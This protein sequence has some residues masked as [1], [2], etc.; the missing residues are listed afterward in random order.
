MIRSKEIGSN[1]LWIR[2][3]ETQHGTMKRIDRIVKPSRKPSYTSRF[4]NLPNNFTRLKKNI[5]P[6]VKTRIQMKTDRAD[7][8]LC[9]YQEA[10]KII[11]KV[12]T[13]DVDKTITIEL[14]KVWLAKYGSDIH[15]D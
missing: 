11:E 8:I 4:G 3:L 6:D 1:G 7:E 15:K 10:R 9:A 13:P 2:E 12:G 14:A 5:T